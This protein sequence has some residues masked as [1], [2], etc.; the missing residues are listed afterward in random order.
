MKMQEV[1][2]EAK[3]AITVKR[4]F[5]DPYEKEG[6]TF[7]PAARVGGGGGG[8]AATIKKAK[9][10]RAAA[11]ESLRVRPAPTSSRTA[12]SPG[13]QRSIPTGSS[14]CSAWWSSCTC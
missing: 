9:R 1:L 12:R 4:V 6:V 3:D 5:A 2:N 10:V 8:A 7:I 14:P 11:S 13:A